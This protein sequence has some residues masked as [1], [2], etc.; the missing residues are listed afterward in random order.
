MTATPALCLHDYEALARR[1][2]PRPLFGYIAG[3]CEDN[4][5]HDENR[6][7]L[8]RLA[9]RPRILRD[10]AA[11]TTSIELFGDTWAAPFGI[12]PMGLSALMA[13][14]GDVALARAAADEQIPMI[15][16]GASLI[17]LEDIAQAAPTAWFQ[18]YLPAE[19]ERIDAMLARVERAGFKTLVLTVDVPV[20]AN[21]ENLL[22]VGFSTP[23]RPSLGLVLEGLTHPRWLFGVFGR[24]LLHHG[25]PH[26]ENMRHVRGEPIL[27]RHVERD[28]GQRERLSWDSLA[29]MRRRWPGRLI[30][31]GILHPDDARLAREHGADGLIVSNHGGRQLDGVCAALEA[32]PAVIDAVGEL[33]VMI[34]SGFRRGSDVLKALAL[35]ARLVFIGRPFLYAAAVGGETEVQRAAQLLKAEIHRNM[36]MLGITE[37]AQLNRD[38][39][40]R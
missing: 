8:C 34:D 30:V 1:R 10:T 35:G 28:F 6:A 5:S 15:V 20:T 32:L 3:A 36:A 26:F 38:Y 40:L 27:S 29:Y 21:R 17:P 16:S 22:R 4:W 24:T 14:R 37:L 7:A 31:K 18:A 33:P 25:L 23:L 39:L 13:Y 9:L 11:R 2:L 19:T 12:A